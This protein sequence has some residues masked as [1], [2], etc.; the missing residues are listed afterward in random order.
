MRIAS[1]ERGRIGPP[2]TSVLRV[3][4]RGRPRCRHFLDV[5][6]ASPAD[7][8]LGPAHAAYCTSSTAF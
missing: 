4:V 6:W 8:P 1:D 5:A 2:P 3:V 7:H